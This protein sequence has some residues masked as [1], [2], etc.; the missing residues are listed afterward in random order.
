MPGS[1]AAAIGSYVERSTAL[2]LFS[3]KV[4]HDAV[5]RRVQGELDLLDVLP[6]NLPEGVERYEDNG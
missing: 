4:I 2:K 6:M 3:E 5:S 1:R